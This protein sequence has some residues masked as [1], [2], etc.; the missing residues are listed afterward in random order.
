M[1]ELVLNLCFMTIWTNFTVP[2]YSVGFISVVISKLTLVTWVKGVCLFAVNLFGSA[3]VIFINHWF[4]SII[5]QLY[6]K[7][8]R[9]K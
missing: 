5:I 6:H 8:K 4:M 1:K 7:D 3:I 2:F 9:N